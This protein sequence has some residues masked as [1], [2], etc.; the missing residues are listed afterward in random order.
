MFF[1]WTRR[2]VLKV[3]IS[4]AKDE[5]WI[6]L[7]E[8]KVDWGESW[9]MRELIDEKVDWWETVDDCWRPLTTI[10]YFVWLMKGFDDRHMDVPTDEQC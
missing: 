1:G 2:K 9:L 7:I 10:W 5:R 8:E 4:R 6:K 3:A